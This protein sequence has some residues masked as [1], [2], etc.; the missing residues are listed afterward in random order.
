MKKKERMPNSYQ[1]QVKVARYD[2]SERAMTNGSN[3]VEG[4]INAD[5]MMITNV[6]AMVENGSVKFSFDKLVGMSYYEI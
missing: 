5:N 1:Y 2:A 6:N 3:V 4:N